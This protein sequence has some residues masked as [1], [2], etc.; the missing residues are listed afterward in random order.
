M[1]EPIRDYNKLGS[2]I[3][4]LMGGDDNITFV[5]HCATRL[6]LKVKKLP[7]GALEAVTKLPGVISVAENGG[8]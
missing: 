8:Q 5:E 3:I 1:A 4:R 7:D 6:R 2:D